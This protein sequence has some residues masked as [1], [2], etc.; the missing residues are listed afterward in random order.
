MTLDFFTELAAWTL[1]RHRY[2][3][4]EHSKTARQKQHSGCLWPSLRPPNAAPPV[5]CW[6]DCPDSRVGTWT[7]P[8]RGSRVQKFATLF[9]SCCLMLCIHCWY[10][11]CFL[12]ALLN[13][14][15]S[16]FW[17]FIST[18]GGERWCFTVDLIYISLINDIEHLCLFLR[19]A[20]IF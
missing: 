18:P 2:E 12:K 17:S 3:E 10:I 13:S 20:F 14:A 5:L 15:G 9:Y 16:S 11:V 7:S 19:S 8:L 6:A 1:R 4:T